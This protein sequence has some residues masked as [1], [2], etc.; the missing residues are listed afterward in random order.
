M[1]HGIPVVPLILILVFSLS[2]CGCSGIHGTTPGEP[3]DSLTVTPV[4]TQRIAPSDVSTGIGPGTNPDN[5]SQGEIPVGRGNYVFKDL[6]GNADR[7]ITVY[8]Y[9]PATWNISG[10][11]LFVMPGAGRSGQPSRDTWV[12]YGDRYSCLVV[13]PEFALANYP[14]DQWYPLGNMIAPSG[15][16]WNPK[17]NWTYTAIEH[18]FDDVRGKTGA[19]S[20]RPISFSGT[21]PGPSSST[22]S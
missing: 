2:A 15:T 7:P 20:T 18:I 16:A 11:I 1:D 22:A 13:V 12:P 5:R 14:D 4:A 3:S 9:R 21:V 17:A 6:H 10:P 19:T 8:T